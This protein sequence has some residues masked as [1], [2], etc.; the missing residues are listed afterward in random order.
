MLLKESKKKVMAVIMAG[1]I[2]TTGVTYAFAAGTGTKTPAAPKTPA[3]AMQKP[4][5]PKTQLDKL[6]KTKTITAAQETVIIKAFNSS[7]TSYDQ[8]LNSLVKSKKITQAQA[9][10]VKK[11][12][13]SGKNPGGAKGN[14]PGGAPGNSK[15]NP[16]GNP[17][18]GAQ[19]KSSSSAK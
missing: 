10:A 3:K 17:P 13:M 19:S 8:V 4:P 11:A 1:V 16:P 6:V 7:K 9:N 18:S 15:G 14:P 12:I 2:A 5:I